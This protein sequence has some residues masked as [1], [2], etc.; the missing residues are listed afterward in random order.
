MYNN[1]DFATLFP[2]PAGVF[3]P[4]LFK[5]MN[6][7]GIAN[8]MWFS[9]RGNK[10]VNNFP[11]Y[12]PDDASANQYT[13]TWN[14]YFADVDNKVP[15]LLAS[16]ITTL[17]GTFDAPVINGATNIVVDVYLPD[18]LGQANGALFN[19]P[20]FGGLTG[21]GFVNGQHTWAASW[22]MALTIPIRPWAR[23]RSISPG[24]AWRAG[25]KSRWP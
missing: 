14:N 23:S 8:D 16:T 13:N 21:E 19:Y 12:N 18:P 5:G 24:W 9:F 17:N 1:N 15:V 20:F 10:S 6:Q 2:T 7:S 3:A 22:T 11:L 25:R 4:S